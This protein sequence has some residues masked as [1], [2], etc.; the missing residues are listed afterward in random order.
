MVSDERRAAVFLDRDGVLNELVHRDGHALSPRHVTEFRLVAGAAEAVQ[1]LR[2]LGFGVFVI[3]NQPDVARGFMAPSELEAMTS[4]LKEAI[5]PDGVAICPHD[6]ADDCNCRKPRPGLLV[7]LA[8]QW[9]LRLARS[10]VVGDSWR[11]IEAGRRA[12]C[13][14][15]FVDLG[16]G[17]VPRL[18][19]G[20]D[21]VVHSLSEAV[22]YIESLYPSSEAPV[23][24]TELFLE[25]ATRIAKA[26]DRDV[27]ERLAQELAAL[28]ERSGR[29]F[30]VG[31]GGGAGHAGHAV[32]DFRKLVGIECYSATDNVSELTARINDEGW[33]TSFSAWL[34]GSRLSAKDGLFVFS[35]GGG[36]LENRVSVNIVNAVRLAKAIGARIL[37]I[38]GRDG[39][40][41][42]A[43]GDAV[44]VVPMVDPA[45]VTPH[46]EAFQA[47]IWHLLVS[48]PLL[49]R[50]TTK[51]ESITQAPLEQGVR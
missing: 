34:E 23:T 26:I 9:S 30:F 11:D 15:I 40:Y 19:P 21:R 43:E 4:R 8:S 33:D 36:S 39:G 32:N 12:G 37:G 50:R 3:T 51:W 18:E 1:R 46:T 47:V 14:T 31:V 27:V 16:M 17:Q 45:L 41:T 38:V 20:A 44:L 49:A 10:F 29:L 35:V 22:T 24:F 25:E 42:A 48:H 7:G 6:D 5:R 28:R 2:R 13:H